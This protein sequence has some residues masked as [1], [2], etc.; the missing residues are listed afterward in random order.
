M[1]A[2]PFGS[3]CCLA[4]TQCLQMLQIEEAACL[5][6]PSQ[7][8]LAPTHMS[9]SFEVKLVS[10]G[11]NSRAHCSQVELVV[12]EMRRSLQR[13]AG[14]DRRLPQFVGM[15]GFQDYAINIVVLVRS[16]L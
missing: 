8:T 16:L 14:V 4:S 3:Q 6:L 7:N 9:G 12:D 11:T 15:S 5:L 1:P 13:R 2:I 10:A